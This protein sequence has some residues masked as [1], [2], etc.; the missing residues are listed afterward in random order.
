MVESV[1]KSES[2]TDGGTD[3]S[4]VLFRECLVL[5]IDQKPYQTDLGPDASTS[6]RPE[7]P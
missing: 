5:D 2:P 1:Y 4:E 3:A 6:D 7:E